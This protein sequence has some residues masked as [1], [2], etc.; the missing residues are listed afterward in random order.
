MP[1]TGCRTLHWCALAAVLTLPAAPIYATPLDADEDG[2]I[3]ANDNCPS[4]LNPYQQDTDV[5]GQGDACDLDDDDDGTPDVDDNCQKTASTDQ[6]DTDRDGVGDAC[7]PDDDDDGLADVLDPC[8][9]AASG[10]SRDLDRDGFGDACDDDDDDDGVGDSADNCAM[11]P[12]PGQEDL[13]LD[14]VGD[15]CDGDLDGDGI[16]N[17]AD[18]CAGVASGDQRDADGDGLAS[19]CDEDDDNDGVPDLLDAC[20]AVPDPIQVDNEV[21]G[22]GDACDDD[23]DN[24]GLPDVEERVAGDDGWVTDPRRADTDGDGSGDGEEVKSGTDPTKGDDYPGHRRPRDA[25]PAGGMG[26]ASGRAGASGLAVLLLGAWLITLRRARVVIPFVLLSAS[27]ASALDADAIRLRGLGL[28][29]LVAA[30]FATLAPLEFRLRLA[31]RFDARP[32]ELRG[33][34]G[35]REIGVIEVQNAVDVG[36][37]VGLLRELELELEAPFVLTRTVGP[38]FPELSGSGPGDLE[39]GLRYRLAG[40]LDE[41]SGVALSARFRTPTGDDDALRGAGA[42]GLE[43]VL[44]AWAVLA[45]VRLMLETGVSYVNA[46]PFMDRRIGVEL[47]MVGGVRVDAVR[48]ALCVEGDVATRGRIGSGG[49]GWPTEV[50]GSLTVFTGPWRIAAGGAVAV[51]DGLGAPAWRL[52]LAIGMGSDPTRDSD[53]DGIRDALDRCPTVP[54]D[55]DDLDDDD[56]CPEAGT[57]PGRGKP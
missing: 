23:D 49:G 15:A 28:G 52:F 45:R 14:G 13:D 31:Y 16:P 33:P 55:H 25:T 50:L 1:N 32:V 10:G 12:N 37:A 53:G 26:C 17:E 3:D 4:I 48:D 36:I 18:L 47:P 40:R 30:P 6:K 51:T 24:D 44:G 57:P 35:H 39:I 43:A 8:P 11:A 56:G 2:V 22:I 46:T 54:E 9:R 5:D 34:D 29:G 41:E 42:A 27:P 7:D 38:D 19:P 20:P 21:D